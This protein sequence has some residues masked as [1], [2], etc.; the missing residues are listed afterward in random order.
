MAKIQIANFDY[1]KKEEV[2]KTSKKEKY[3][4]FLV[5]KGLEECEVLANEFR[6]L[7]QVIDESTIGSNTFTN[8]DSFMQTNLV[9]LETI[10]PNIIAGNYDEIPNVLGVSDEEFVK[11]S[12]ELRRLYIKNLDEKYNSEY[13]E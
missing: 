3:I 8:F 12:R 2:S 10:I 11:S 7:N 5:E 4:K 1:V 9:S 13:Q 6:K